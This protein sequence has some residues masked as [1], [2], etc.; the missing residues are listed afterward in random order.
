MY[1]QRDSLIIE[2]ENQLVFSK[3]K[4]SSIMGMIELYRFISVILTLSIYLIHSVFEDY[5]VGTI[6]LLV[7]CVASFT[8]LINYLYKKSYDN[9]FRMRLLLLIEIVGISFL[10][11]L[12]GGLKSPFIWCY[13]NPLL[14]ISYY[15][16]PRQK[17][18]YLAV[19]Y[20][21][22]IGIGYFAESAPGF[23]EFFMDN[24]NVILSFILLLILFNILF[25]YNRQ[26]IRKQDELQ[27]ANRELK[28]YNARINGM[29][30]D[31]LYMYE[32][33]QTI[34][35]QRGRNEIIH[36]LMD[37][38]ERVSPECITFYIPDVFSNTESFIS[39]NE[40]NHEI[41]DKLVDKYKNNKH[42]IKE[43]Q[44]FAFSPAD[45]YNALICKLSY[46]KKFG[47]IGLLV[48]ED[49]Y[50][51]NKTEY[52][53]ILLLISQLGETFFEKNETEM[54]ERELVVA[55][56]QDRIADDIHDSVIQLLFATSCFAY[57][58]IKKWENL[59]DDDKKKQ[60]TKMMEAIASSLKELRSTIYNL[61]SK[62]QQISFFKDSIRS[63]LQELESLT[64]I[65]INL[66][67]EGDAENLSFSAKKT[68]YRI[69]TECTGNAIK[70]S[71]C[72]NIWV[73]LHIGDI[74]TN[75]SI[76]DDGIGLDLNKATQEKNGLG[77]YNIKSLIRSFNGTY[78]ILSEPNSGTTFDI[79]F[80]NPDIIKKPDVD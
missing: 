79:E 77:L 49:E 7:L 52:E 24:S 37:F 80:N 39:S 28:R 36:V 21:I 20:I 44:I 69:I 41:K 55:Y 8:Q 16:Y 53:T 75:L 5:K 42:D 19:S 29:I 17:V 3:L 26:I 65:K 18:L 64:G 10:I 63:Y 57:N 74:K 67:I 50:K 60:M 54:V 31:M 61:S 46:I 68:L 58:T 23:P 2:G 47:A 22:F 40:I 62:K 32:A 71:K 33:V 6:I 51:R 35:G 78:K 72:D 56:E 76:K 66:D 73:V 1:S 15:M 59:S 25:D 14:L 43:N 70:H 30:R 11:I 45:G 4:K 48:T 38:A 34:S 12:T 9:A 13:L 27:A